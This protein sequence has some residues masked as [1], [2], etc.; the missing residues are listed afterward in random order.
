MRSLQ[1]D[2]LPKGASGGEVKIAVESI[3]PLTLIT[4]ATGQLAAQ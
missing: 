3:S 2:S 1:S 4:R